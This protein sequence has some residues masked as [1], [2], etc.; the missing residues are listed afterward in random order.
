[1]LKATFAEVILLSYL[2][3]RVCQR[4]ATASRIYAVGCNRVRSTTPREIHDGERVLGREDQQSPCASLLSLP[5][6][7]RTPPSTVTRL[8]S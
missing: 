5:K 4:I 6:K 2:E 3:P 8:V 7:Q 1:M